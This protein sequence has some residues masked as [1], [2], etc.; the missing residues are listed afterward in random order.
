MS[1]RWLPIPGYE[2][3]YDVS[4]LGHVRSWSVRNRNAAPRSKALQPHSTGYPRLMLYSGGGRYANRFV[5]QLVAAAFIGPRP[6]G[7]QVRHLDGNRSN[8]RLTNLAYGTQSENALDA[9]RH[10]TNVNAAKTHCRLGHP[11]DAANTYTIGRRRQC[12]VC[13]RDAV[14]RYQA[15]KAAA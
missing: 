6:P 13:N 10:G 8:P 14:A 11:Y 12:R 1:E 2:G 4:D 3:R 9:V 7:Q 15:R 5:H